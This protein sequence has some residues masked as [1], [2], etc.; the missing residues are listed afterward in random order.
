MDVARRPGFIVQ[1]IAEGCFD[2]TDNSFVP[3]TDYTAGGHPVFG[4]R[5]KILKISRAGR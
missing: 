4:L 2:R 1:V 5:L 3:E